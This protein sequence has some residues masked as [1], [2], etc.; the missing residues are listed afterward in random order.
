MN[1]LLNIVLNITLSNLQYFLIS[2]YNSSGGKKSQFF[3][4]FCYMSKWLLKEYTLI[5]FL[6]IFLWC[7]KTLY[8]KN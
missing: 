5:L 2:I 1:L 7:L 3:F 8:I 4:F 6:K